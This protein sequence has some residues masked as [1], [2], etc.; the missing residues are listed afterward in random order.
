MQPHQM[1][2]SYRQSINRAPRRRSS[3]LGS[4]VR[5][6]VITML[7]IAAAIGGLWLVGISIGLVFG[8]LALVMSLAPILFV[9]WL[10]WL[11]V[12]P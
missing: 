12:R 1:N 2:N 11:V 5:A 8:L 4:L 10:V 3:M 9:A 7:W 6:L